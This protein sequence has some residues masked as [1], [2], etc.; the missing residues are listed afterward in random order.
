MHLETEIVQCPYCWSQI[1]IVLDPSDQSDEFIEDCFVCCRPIHFYRQRQFD[2]SVQLI[3]QHEDE[4][5]D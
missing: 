3:A 4:A 2:G 1:E 5:Y